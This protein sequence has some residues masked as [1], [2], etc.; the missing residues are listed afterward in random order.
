MN[1]SCPNCG[2]ELYEGQQFCRRCGTPVGAAAGGEAPTRLF[3]GGAQAGPAAPAAEGTTP[4]GGNG[5]RTDSVAGQRPTEYQ[6]QGGQQTSA[7]VGEPFGSRPLAVGGPPPPKRRAGLWLFALLAVFVLGAGLASAAAFL[8]W[9]ATHTG[10]VVKVVKT[11]PPV[12]PG[13]PDVP[14]IPDVPEIPADLGER[15]KEALK[16]HGIP[17]PLDESGAVV[18][19]DDTTL[20]R[21]Y[22]LDPDASFTAHVVSGNVTVV[23]SDDADETVVKV[24]KHGGSVQ[25]RAATKVLAAES[26]E[27]VMLVGAAAPGGPVSVSYQITVPRRGLHKLEL[28]AQKG[29]IKVSGFDGELDLNVM[30]GNVSVDTN[31]AVRSRVVN[32]RTSVAY[33]GRHDE[34]QEFSV[35]NGD[36]EVSLTGEPEVDLSAAST[37]GRVE[38]DG[39]LPV[40]TEKGGRKVEAELGGGG[41]PLNVKVVNGNIRIKQ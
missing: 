23:G 28:S 2:A 35:V 17:L 33:A 22:S 27:G 19:G 24:V 41:A 34:P 29:D 8:W 11:G 7:L 10:T 38:V 20:T 13:V 30:N 32:G 15:I 9:R 39:A 3:Q 25:E 12:P 31:G 36:L 21:T 14:P 40:K 18:S 26:D 4:L 16:G 37:N 6:L 1:E 5:A